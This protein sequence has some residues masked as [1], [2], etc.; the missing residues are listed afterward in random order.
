MA[1]TAPKVVV[2]GMEMGDGQLLHTWAKS[3][4]LPY[5]KSLIERGC[6]GWLDTTADQLHISAWPSIY[7]GAAPGEHGVYFTFQP[8][9]GLQGYQ[10]FHTGLYGRPTFWKLLDQAGRRCTVFDPPYS[11]P[12]IGYGGTYIYDWG[13]WAHYLQT[14]SVPDTLLKQLNKSCGAYPLGLEAHDFGWRPLEPAAI[15]RRLVEAVKAKTTATCWLMR[16]SAWDMAFTVFGETHVAGHY[17][18]LKDSVA[19]A[20]EQRPM[21]DLYQELDRAIASIHAAAGEDATFV[22]ISG[23]R[24][25]PNNAG[26][27]MLPDILARLGYLANGGTAPASTAVQPVKATK[28]FDPVKAL[29]DMLP[30]NFRKNLASLLPTAIRDKLAQRVDNADIDWSQTRAYCLPTDLEGYIRVN[31]KG[32]EPQGIVEPGAEYRDVLDGLTGALGELRDPATGLAIVREVIRTDSAFPGDR[33]AYLP[34]LIVHW[35]AAHPITCACSLGIGT[36]TKVSEDQR[37]GTHAGPGFVLAAG[38]GIAPGQ[39][40]GPAHI[41]DFAPTLLKRMGVAAPMHMRGRVWPELKST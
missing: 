18:L 32:R 33:R 6:W 35:N 8:A 39:L 31:L 19:G 16:Q 21:L 22:V 20:A 30:K 4:Q 1:A 13:S 17:C 14:G 11:H 34:D 38:P 12:E 23:D 36:I 2:V 5:I 3:G 28:K 41:F 40:Q 37:P 26:W 25:A 7:T 9:P 10:R 29:R 15:S 27:H 24:V